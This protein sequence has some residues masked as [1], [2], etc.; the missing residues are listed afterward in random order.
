M[1]E[2][3]RDE[4]AAIICEK[5]EDG[6]PTYN[7]T[8]NQRAAEIAAY[9]VIA[10]TCK[11]PALLNLGVVSAELIEII[12]RNP[13]PAPRTPRIEQQQPEQALL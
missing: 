4:I 13:A 8:S 11:I 5:D 3:K 6:D 10:N 7:D 2:D 1:G 9:L 12:N